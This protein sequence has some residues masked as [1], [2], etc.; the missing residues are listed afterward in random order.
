MCFNQLRY[1]SKRYSLCVDYYI[2]MNIDIAV[3]TETFFSC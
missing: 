2:Y 3:I 1:I